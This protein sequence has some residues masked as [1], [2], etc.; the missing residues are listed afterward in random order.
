MKMLQPSGITG[1]AEHFQVETT[2]FYDCEPDFFY[3]R[4]EVLICFH[5]ERASNIRMAKFTYV[6][7][8]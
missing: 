3:I 7:C 6:I 8:E 5:V 1:Q 4:N 2:L